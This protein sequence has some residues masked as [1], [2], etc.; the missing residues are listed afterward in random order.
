MLTRASAEG[1]YILTIWYTGNFLITVGVRI[2]APP[3]LHV[4]PTNWQKY[5]QHTRVYRLLTQREPNAS[6]SRA[7]FPR[8]GALAYTFV[9][10]HVIPSHPSI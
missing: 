4:Q 7:A 9:E 3:R 2:F 5:T 10:D 1:W 8:V 6:G